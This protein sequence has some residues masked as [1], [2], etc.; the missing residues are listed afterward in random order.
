M[1]AGGIEKSVLSLTAPGLEAAFDREEAISDATA[2]NDFL[3]QQ[4][5]RH[6][7]RLGGFA[8]LPMRFPD[9]AAE[10]LQ[11]AVTTSTKS[12]I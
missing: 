10:E 8:A 4:I 3:A 11:R 9:A 7:D 12:V 6:P 2:I 5:E 1:D